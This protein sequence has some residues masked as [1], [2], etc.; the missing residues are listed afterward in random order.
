MSVDPLM[1][2]KEAIL[3]STGFIERNEFTYNDMLI[4]KKRVIEQ[5]YDIE[6]TT[7][8]NELFDPD[9]KGDFV[10]EGLGFSSVVG[11]LYSITTDLTN[12]VASDYNP[13]NMGVEQVTLGFIAESGYSLPYDYDTANFSVTNAT[14][15]DW[16]VVT[17][18]LVISN[19]T[20]NVTITIKGV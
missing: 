10:L 12:V 8:T 4:D 11:G 18:I 16:S 15:V 17:G 2:F 20:G 7:I 13:N 5:G 3:Q 9:S 14:V 1:S 19:A 6:T